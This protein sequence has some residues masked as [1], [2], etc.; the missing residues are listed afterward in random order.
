MNSILRFVMGKRRFCLMFHL[1]RVS[2]TYEF[3]GWW[4]Q[5]CVFYHGHRSSE[6]GVA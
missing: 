6:R 3:F 5:P 4:C 1:P 2:T